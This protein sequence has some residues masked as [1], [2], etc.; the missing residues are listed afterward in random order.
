M[1]NMKIF[2]VL[3]ISYATKSIAQGNTKLGTN[4]LSSITTG[5]YNTALGFYSLSGNTEGS[6]NTACDAYSAAGNY[7]GL[8]F[9]AIRVQ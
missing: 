3:C 2:A 6:S 7:S 1:K 9:P 8:I 4:A 5:T